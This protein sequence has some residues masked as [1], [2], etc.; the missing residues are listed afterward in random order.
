ML[1]PARQLAWN[2]REGSDIVDSNPRDTIMTCA[3][4]G[5]S[6]VLSFCL[7]SWCVPIGAFTFGTDFGLNHL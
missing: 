7:F 4:V 3:L 6:S 5:Y 1:E 2:K